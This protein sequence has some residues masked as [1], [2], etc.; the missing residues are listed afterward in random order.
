MRNC[1]YLFGSTRAHRARIKQMVG[2]DDYTARMRQFLHYAQTDQ[3]LPLEEPVFIFSAGWRTGSTLL[4][5]LLSSSGSLLLWGE[6]Y[7]RSNIIQSLAS[8]IEPFSDKWPPR[9]YITDNGE[10]EQNTNKWIANFYPRETHLLAAHRNFIRTLFAPSNEKDTSKRWG[11]KEV[12]YGLREAVFLKT[13]FP[14]AKFLY[15]QRDLDDA[16]FSY[17]N[18]NQHMNWYANWPHNTVFTPYAFAKHRARLIREFSQAQKLTGGLIL[19]YHDIVSDNDTLTKIETYCNVKI[20]RKT[21]ENKVGNALER[22]KKPKHRAAISWFESCLLRS[23]NFRGAKPQLRLSIIKRVISFIEQRALLPSTA[24]K[25]RAQF[26]KQDVSAE[27]LNSQHL[28]KNYQSM[29]ITDDHP[30]FENISDLFINC[31]EP[32]SPAHDDCL[33][34]IIETRCH[35][36]LEKVVVD[37][38]ERTGFRAQLFHGRLNLD[39]ILSSRIGKLIDEKKVIL[40]PLN[41]DEINAKTYNAI[42]LSNT[43]WMLLDARQKI[44]VF[45]TDSLLCPTS[46]KPLSEFLHFDYIGSWWPRLR[47]IGITVDGGNGG[48]SIRSWQH[49]VDCLTRFDP[50]YWPG[51]EDSYFAFHIDL[52]DGN[53]A[54]GHTCAQFSTQYRFL[55]NSYGCHKISCLNNADKNKFLRFFKGASILLPDDTSH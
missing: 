7:D 34:V 35:P 21:L 3:S 31:N 49:S 44:F 55:F 25:L 27:Q 28:L 22:K 52:L 45:Q 15:L 42:F 24:Q 38:V 13:L 40:S 12:R 17:K 37:F 11:I 36:L 2:A 9:K 16:Y 50:T 10:F 46:Q 19:H 23:G 41:T 14:N 53:V 20:D 8:T 29:P 54:R 1:A 39:F 43:F 4:Q 6:P 26:A 48:L 32:D 33:G 30:E 51:G 5:R 18:F 47:P